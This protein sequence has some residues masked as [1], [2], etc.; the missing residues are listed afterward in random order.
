MTAHNTENIPLPH[1][2][3]VFENELLAIDIRCK[4]DW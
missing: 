2:L 1:F 3:F 4:D